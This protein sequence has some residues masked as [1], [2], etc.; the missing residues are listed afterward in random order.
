MVHSLLKSKGLPSWLWGEVVT[1]AVYL[2]NRSPTKGVAEKTSFE[3]W[4]CKKPGVRHLRTF[5]CIIHV[6]HTVPNLKKLDDCS[7]PMVFFRYE[8]GSKAY[9]AYDLVTKKVHLSRDV[10]FDEQASWDWSIG[11]ECDKMI[12]DDDTFIVEMEY[13][14]VNQV[15][16]VAIASAGT[17]TTASLIRSPEPRSPTPAIDGAAGNDDQAVEPANPLVVREE[18][19]NTDH[20]KDATLRL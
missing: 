16:L 4:F 15:V 10:I 12:S 19:L 9:H 7:P 13:S 14:T 11:G 2:M 5:G 17:P 18:D 8:L 6:K 3:A 1:T 20:D